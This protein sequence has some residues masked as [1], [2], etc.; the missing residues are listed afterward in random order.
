MENFITTHPVLFIIIIV[1][2]G[3][4][5]LPW[6]GYA[7]WLAARRHHTWWFIVLLLVNTVGIL[8]ILYIFLVGRRTPEQLGASQSPEQGT[9]S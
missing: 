8:E 7:L 4:W 3:L 5:T 6:K 9:L 2:I 1:A